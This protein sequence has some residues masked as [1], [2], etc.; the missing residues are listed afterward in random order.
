MCL[1]VCMCVRVCVCVS[2]CVVCYTC[3]TMLSTSLPVYQVKLDWSPLLCIALIQPS[4]LSCLGSSV[5][6]ASASYVSSIQIL[7]EQLFFIGKRNVQDSCSCI[8]LF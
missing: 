8:A 6:R 3:Y 7:P 4:Q 5:G 2:V 1:F